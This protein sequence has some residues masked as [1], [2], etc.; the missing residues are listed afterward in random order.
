MFDDVDKEFNR[1]RFTQE[2]TLRLLREQHRRDCRSNLMAWAIEALS[3]TEYTPAR[4]HQLLIEKLT[5]VADGKIKRLMVL[6]PPGSAKS[7]YASMIFPAWWFCR[8]P[9]SAVIGASHTAELAD[10]FGRKVRNLTV[11][12][13]ATLGYSLLPDN[14]AAGRWETNRGGEYFAVGVGGAVTGRRSDLMIIDDP[15]KSKE[16]AESETVRNKVWDWYRDDLYTRMKPGA[17]IVLIMTRWHEADLGGRLIENMQ[18]GGDQWDVLKLPAFATDAD[19]PLGRA[20]GEPLWPEWESEGELAMKRQTLGERDFG[21]LFQQDPRPAGTSFFDV[22]NILL[23]GEPIE[24]PPW[25]DTVFATM[26]TAVKTGSKND[27]TGVI[28]WAFNPHNLNPLTIIDWDIK[29]I[30]GALLEAWLP[31]VFQNLQEYAVRYKARMG[32]AGVHIEDKASGTILLQQSA[33]RAQHPGPG[34]MAHAINSKLTAVGKDERAISVSAYVQTQ[35]VR[36]IREAYDKAM[37]YKSQHGNH[38]LM[39]VFRF[40]IG[41]KDQADDLLDCFCY[42]IAI[43]LGDRGGF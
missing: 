3:D 20:P 4:H 38:L 41:V 9:M 24:P 6:M 7:T 27:G 36:I 30:E 17:A 32:S 15:I 33:R 13:S 10:R 40:Q 25:C 14:R 39:Q 2:R 19:D 8:H 1:D 22:Q 29:Q 23:G 18:I 11:L 5:A 31:T 34:W 37:Q 42:G 43:A 21:A 35:K 26:D 16:D 28:Y 12:H